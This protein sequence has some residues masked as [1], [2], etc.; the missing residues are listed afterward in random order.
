MPYWLGA[1]PSAQLNLSSV[2]SMQHR[3][4]M[5]T[6][7][8]S[9][10]TQ[11]RLICSWC[12]RIRLRRAAQ[13]CAERLISMQTDMQTEID[14]ETNVDMDIGV[15]SIYGPSALE[16]SSQST[17]LSSI[18]SNNRKQNS[19]RVIECDRVRVHLQTVLRLHETAASCR[20]CMVNSQSQSSGVLL[21]DSVI[22]DLGYFCQGYFSN[23]DSS[24]IT[25]AQNPI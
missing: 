4:C 23:L 3:R 10:T 11:I 14:M 17:S 8:V 22:H 7:I 19:Q 9:L 15:K 21:F 16:R 2:R 5:C 24:D 13:I 18:Q 12:M 25:V 1:L 6:C 20:L